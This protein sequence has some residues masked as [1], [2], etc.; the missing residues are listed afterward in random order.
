M[1]KALESDNYKIERNENNYT[2]TVTS[3]YIPNTYLELEVSELNEVS[4]LLKQA[5]EL[6]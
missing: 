2:F 5:Q 4:E 6:L 3:K 1:L